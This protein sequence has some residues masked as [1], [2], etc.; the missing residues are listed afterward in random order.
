MD[1][2]IQDKRSLLSQLY[3]VRHAL[4]P[5][6]TV[7]LTRYQN[8]QTS[9]KVRNICKSKDIYNELLERL[10][11]DKND[12]YDYLPRPMKEHLEND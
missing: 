2:I 8:D 3:N 6:Y 5:P 1:A 7:V 4:L 10:L 11:S 9:N 12:N